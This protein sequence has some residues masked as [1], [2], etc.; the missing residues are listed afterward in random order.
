MAT[1]AIY[2]RLN[3]TKVISS[4]Y[5]VTDDACGNDCLYYS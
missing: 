4:R 3:D 1:I 5:D 2:E